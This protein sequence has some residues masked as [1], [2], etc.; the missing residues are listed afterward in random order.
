MSAL[1]SNIKEPILVLAQ[2]KVP[3][4]GSKRDAAI[5][6]ME[7]LGFLEQLTVR[8]MKLA[9]DKGFYN[10]FSDE[11][12]DLPGGKSAA[13]L[14]VDII[15]K[16]L[17]GTY[18]WDE[19]KQPNFYYFCWS[20]AESILS[21]WLDKHRRVTTMS[22][23]EEE[24]ENG[25]PGVNAVNSVA[26]GKDI[27]DVLRFRNGGALGDKLLEEFALNLPDGSHEQAILMAIHDDREC[28]NRAYCRG[29][30]SLSEP[31]YDAAM[32]RIR[33]AAPRFFAEWCHQNNVKD[34]DRKEVQ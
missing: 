9:A 6:A 14:A 17:D 16:A 12:L 24:N 27:Y 1:V 23:M 18:T 28:A 20:R 21:N 30:L 4:S 8:I 19:T 25:E 5:K 22:P 10:P 15:E 3:L 33:R 26:D 2:E 29:K 34:D 31:D 13:D 7:T 11:D 32:K